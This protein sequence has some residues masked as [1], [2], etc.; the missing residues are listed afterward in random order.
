MKRCDWF[1][2]DTIYKKDYMCCL[3]NLLKPRKKSEK[4]APDCVS[5]QF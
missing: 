1:L 5:S 4:K 2:I 3:S